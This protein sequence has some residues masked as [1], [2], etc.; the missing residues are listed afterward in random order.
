MAISKILEE[1][2]GR[3]EGG[4]GEEQKE[5]TWPA[6]HSGHKTH[7][8]TQQGHNWSTDVA[9]AVCSVL[10]VLIGMHEVVFFSCV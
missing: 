8:N 1:R 7:Y 3:G 9:I 5:K 6:I 10:L 2:K 4:T